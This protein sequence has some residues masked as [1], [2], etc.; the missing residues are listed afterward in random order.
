MGMICRSFLLRKF[1]FFRNFGNQWRSQ[2]VG[3]V[4]LFNASVR[5]RARLQGEGQFVDAICLLWLGP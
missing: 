4:R 3:S 2:K 1:P 5:Q